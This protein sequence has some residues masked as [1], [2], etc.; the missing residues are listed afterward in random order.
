MKKLRAIVAQKGLNFQEKE[1]SFWDGASRVR[2][3]RYSCSHEHT[4]GD[5]PTCDKEPAAAVHDDPGATTRYRQ[6]RGI[7]A[8]RSKFP[9]QEAHTGGGAGAHLH[10][11]VLLLHSPFGSVTQDS[12]CS[13]VR[14]QLADDGE[15]VY[16]H[17]STCDWWLEEQAKIEDSQDL[18]VFDLGFDG[19]QLGRVGQQECCPVYMTS[20]HLELD[21]MRQRESKMVVGFIEKAAIRRSVKKSVASRRQRRSLLSATV[22]KLVQPLKDCGQ[23]VTARDSSGR[24]RMVHLRLKNLT[25]DHE[26]AW[27]AAATYRTVCTDCRCVA[28]MVAGA[29]RQTQPC[30]PCADARA[31]TCTS[32][33]C[34]PKSAPTTQRR[35]AGRRA[36]ARWK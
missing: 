20:A 22:S 25:L 24:S 27:R 35:R 11:S 12:C 16:G 3:V 36:E 15:R 31:Q 30:T 28:R 34:Q 32:L 4:I 18:C 33:A 9:R 1:I 29:D 26:D 21:D 19:A 2:Q 7:H 23:V 14:S 10:L 13:P 8:R 5:R 6:V 17:P